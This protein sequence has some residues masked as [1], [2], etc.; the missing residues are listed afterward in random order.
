MDFET[1]KNLVS[2]Y[3]RNDC[4]ELNFQ[5][6]II[7]PFLEGI[8]CG[9]YDVV[10]SSTLFKNWKKINRDQFA[11]N[12]TP[13]IL[14]VDNWKLFDEKKKKPLLIIEVKRPTANDRYHA[15]DEVEEYLNKSHYVILTDCITWEIYE[16]GLKDPI[17]IFLAKDNQMVC[18]RNAS[19]N[20][21]E[22]I[23][24]WIDTN[25]TNNAWIKLCNELEAI[26]NERISK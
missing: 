19:N 22:R 17:K 14:V 1:Y 24:N 13:D 4:R 11:G 9:K 25:T 21:D 10:D 7:I 20:E 8:F 2:K 26:T 6:R 5:N 15:E 18:E 23:I 16:K 3:Y 12:Y